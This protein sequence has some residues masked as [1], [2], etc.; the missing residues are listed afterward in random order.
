MNP[1]IKQVSPKC[2]LKT[3]IY[4]MAVTDCEPGSST[5]RRHFWKFRLTG[6]IPI[7]PPTVKNFKYL[8]KWI[9]TLKLGSSNYD[10][11]VEKTAQG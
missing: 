8:D 7:F 11:S 5:L 3:F 10:S 2:E 9:A 1:S 4:F 6:F